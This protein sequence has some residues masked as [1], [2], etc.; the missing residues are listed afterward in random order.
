MRQITCPHCADTYPDF[1]VA[2]V[3][4]KGP[5]APKI[6]PKMNERIRELAKQAEEQIKAEYE[7]ESRRNRRLYNEIFLPKFAELIVRE[8]EKVAKDGTWYYDT[9]S[10]RSGWQNPINHVCNV[11]KEHFGVKE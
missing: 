11:M 5:Y 10:L 7:D 2:H 1:D 8:C 4:S 9:P 6:K 3:C